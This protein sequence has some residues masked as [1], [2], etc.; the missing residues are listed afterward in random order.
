M[1]K[2]ILIGEVL[3]DIIDGSRHIGGAPVN[4]ALNL[5]SLGTES[6][7]VSSVGEDEPGRAAIN[8]LKTNGVK[9][10]LIK[11]NPN[12][13]T[14]VAQV[15]HDGEIN[16]FVLSTP[17]AYDFPTLDKNDVVFEPDVIV[18][19]TLASFR[20]KQT[21]QTIETAVHYFP[22]ALKFLDVNL[23]APFFDRE[24]VEKLISVCDILK[25]NDEE[26]QILSEMM[27]QK[28]LDIPSWGRQMIDRFG[29]KCVIVTCGA[30]GAV[31][32]MGNGCYYSPGYKANVIDTVGA[33]DA[34]SAGFLN[35][36]LSRQRIA[37]ALYD[38]CHQGSKCVSHTGAF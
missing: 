21:F 7:I 17:A 20:S 24:T 11:M 35:T 37:D 25:C 34:F 28:K 19:G 6:W 5:A 38:G 18:F 29:C 23:R 4:C 32:I 15:I 1:K 13:K 31:A 30:A 8:Y 2:V 12:E 9:T 3:W 26:S 22:K 27:F 16:S 14:G 10:D 33:G 36:Y